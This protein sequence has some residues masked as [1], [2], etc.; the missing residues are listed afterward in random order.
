MIALPAGECCVL[1]PGPV[2]CRLRKLTVTAQTVLCGRTDVCVELLHRGFCI[3][4]DA[5]K[6]AHGDVNMVFTSQHCV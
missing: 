2:R 1:W 6:M 4:V 5:C 3:V